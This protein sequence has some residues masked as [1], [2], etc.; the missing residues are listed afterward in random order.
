MD[1]KAAA[2]RIVKRRTRLKQAWLPPVVFAI[3]VVDA[4]TLASGSV[5]G[6]ILWPF[7]DRPP[8]TLVWRV[9]VYR[10]DGEPTFAGERGSAPIA[11]AEYQL[12]AWS[13]PLWAPTS[14]SPGRINISAVDDARLSGRDVETIAADMRGLLARRLG[15]AA[16]SIPAVSRSRRFDAWGVLGVVHNV[17]TLVIVL[18]GLYAAPTMFATLARWKRALDEATAPKTPAQRRR[19]TLEKGLC[20]GCRYDVRGLL[21]NRCPE[22]GIRWPLLEHELIPATPG[23][24]DGGA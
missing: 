19:E 11:V 18:I 2:G 3:L 17:A 9:G 5:L 22:C 13:R 12:E 4:A 16:S 20:P 23:A 14:F 15:S 1:W 8:S 7:R 24:G 10:V 21:E 6:S